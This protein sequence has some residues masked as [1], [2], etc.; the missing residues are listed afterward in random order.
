MWVVSQ[1]AVDQVFEEVTEEAGSL[2]TAMHLPELVVGVRSRENAVELVSFVGFG[3]RRVLALE[4]E[5]DDACCEQVDLGA[6]VV[7]VL[8]NLWSHVGFSA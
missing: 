1:H 8:V 5:E 7:F 2:R 6:I 3:E 4:D